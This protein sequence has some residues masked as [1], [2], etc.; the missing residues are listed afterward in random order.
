MIHDPD[1]EYG[2]RMGFSGYESP[3]PPGNQKVPFTV[4]ELGERL[5]EVAR[6]LH[7]AFRNTETRIDNILVA[8]NLL[9]ILQAEI[10]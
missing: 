7:L 3:L 6:E 10:D 4:Y 9:D 5:E 8:L 1:L 2:S